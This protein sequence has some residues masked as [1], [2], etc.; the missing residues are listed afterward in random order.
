MNLPNNLHTNI[1]TDNMLNNN[2]K[3]YLFERGIDEKTAHELGFFSASKSTAKQL[4]SHG[5][6]GLV[7][8]YF[9]PTGEQ[10]T[11]RLRPFANDWENAKELRDFFLK[12]NGKLPKFLSIKGDKN[13]PYLTPCLNWNNIFK[14]TSQ[15]LIITEGEIKGVS[16]CLNKIPTIALS[17]ANN[18]VTTND[19]GHSEFLPELETIKW[20]NR[21]VG[22]CFDSDIITNIAVQYAAVKLA[23]Q[24]ARRQA[25]PFLVV[26]PRELNGDKN[27]IDDFIVKHG[28]KAF[29]QLINWH[30]INQFSGDKNKLLI[31]DKDNQEYSL[32]SFEPIV[33]IKGLMAWSV[34][35]ENWRYRPSF[36]WCKWTGKY[37]SIP[38]DGKNGE[39]ALLQE[40][41]EFCRAQNWLYNNNHKTIFDEVSVLLFDF[42]LESQWNPSNILGF[43][44]GYLNT[45]TNE[46]LPFIKEN[47]VTS[48]L[49]FDYNPIASCEQWENY[50]NFTFKGD[51]N[52]IEYIRAWMRWILTP[53]DDRE[54]PIEATLWIVGKPGLGKGT[55]LSVLHSLC[56]QNNIGIFEPGDINDAN[57]LFSLVDKKLAFNNDVEA[58]IPNIPL[59]NSICS[60]ETVNVKH[61]YHDIFP[62]RLNT[63]TVLAMNKE[64]SFKG[65][66]SEGLKRRL[67]VVRFDREPEKRDTDLKAKL[68][69]ELSGIFS[70]VWGLSFAQTKQ[71]L[72][73]RITEDV[74]EVFELNHPEIEFLRQKFP[75]G[76]NSIKASD[77]YKEYCEWCEENG[78]ES[79]KMKSFGYLM[80]QVR[81][82][83]RTKHRDGWYYFIPEMKDYI[84][85][86]Q[87]DNTPLNVLLNDTVTDYSSVTDCDGYPVTDS[88]PCYDSG[89]TD[90]TDSEQ[91][92]FSEEKDQV[93][94]N[95]SMEITPQSCTPQSEPDLQ[96]VTENYPQSVTEVKTLIISLD[97]NQ[98]EIVKT[99]DDDLQSL[100]ETNLNETQLSKVIFGKIKNEL[101]RLRKNK[102]WS[103]LTFIGRYSHEPKEATYFELLD[104]CQY[105]RRQNPDN[106]PPKE[107]KPN[108]KPQSPKPSNVK[109]FIPKPQQPEFNLSDVLP[110]LTQG[111]GK[112]KRNYVCPCC[113]KDYLSANPS[114]GYKCFNPETNCD[115]KDIYKEF[116]KI[117]KDCDPNWKQWDEAM[118]QWIDEVNGGK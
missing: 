93:E 76:Q 62:T 71:I 115:T 77:L 56:G 99:F 16:A 28:V 85:I 82:I 33:S 29:E 64:V 21:A 68:R 65:A 63:V 49:P 105:L 7:I 13:K 106:E 118:K 84:E 46:F 9:S 72:K 15:D 6:G 11:S 81:G 79:G 69:E 114:K 32:G 17:G 2:A 3:S 117:L 92:F 103:K 26:L 34:L 23:N 107:K 73:W 42:P 50:L 100:I 27:G 98:Q 57:K 66:G 108:P 44:N 116:I 40:V 58:F 31:W 111:T 37:W 18:F 10:W 75:N 43:N 87:A 80:Q 30:K 54:Y 95:L 61:L 51:R 94:S 113:E 47:Y 90:V 104:Y 4:L 36:G 45:D 53:K 22:I 59:Y 86:N 24:L 52:K 97:E 41:K 19:D 70:W 91:N 78:Y 1:I 20:E 96:S 74:S 55:F 109:K 38:N 39:N 25:K 88:N 89:V 14:K 101:Q 12:E 110:H 67:H 83:E 112:H 48:I 5:V 35:K 8:P 60:N 102:E